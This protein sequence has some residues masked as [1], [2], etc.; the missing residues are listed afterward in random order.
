MC[1]GHL[2]AFHR[3]PFPQR[4]SCWNPG[5]PGFLLEEERGGGVLKTNSQEE[6][7]PKYNGALGSGVQRQTPLSFP[8]FHLLILSNIVL[9]FSFLNGNG[10][11]FH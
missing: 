8:T 11:R 3:A 1:A 2:T 7:L 4:N 9:S 10:I 6:K 5:T